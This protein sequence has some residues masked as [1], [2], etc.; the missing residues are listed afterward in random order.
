MTSSIT[1]PPPG[2]AAGPPTA[3]PLWPEGGGLPPVPPAPV[4]PAPPPCPAAPLAPPPPP[5][6]GV[7]G[8]SAV[9]TSAL[10]TERPASIWQR[11]WQNVFKHGLIALTSAYVISGCQ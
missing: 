6:P 3:Q 11:S 5:V 9:Q 2:A 7:P 10:Q 4:V 1:N 8:A